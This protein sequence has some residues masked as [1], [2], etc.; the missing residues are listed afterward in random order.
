M[1]GHIKAVGFDVGIRLLTLAGGR[2]ELPE[3][4]DVRGDACSADLSSK[5]QGELEA[6]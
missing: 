4:C 5:E 6:A 1:S 2:I 3:L